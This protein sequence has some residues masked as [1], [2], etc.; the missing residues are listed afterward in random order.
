LTGYFHLK[1]QVVYFLYVESPD[2]NINYHHLHS[3]ADY[4][5][6]T[7]AKS[8]FHG[9]DVVSDIVASKVPYDGSEM[10]EFVIETQINTLYGIEAT[11]FTSVQ[12]NDKIYFVLNREYG[13]YSFNFHPQLFAIDTLGQ[14]IFSR[15]FV[16]VEA[17]FEV[18][19][20]IN[21]TNDNG[22]VMVG[23]RDY[24][25]NNR[26]L[27]M[28]RLDSL[29]H[30]L[31]EKEIYYQAQY[32]AEGFCVAQMPDGDFIISGSTYIGTSPYG[33]FQIYYARTDSMGNVIWEHD[34]GADNVLDAPAKVYLENDT[35][36]IIFGGYNQEPFIGRVTGDGELYDETYLDVGPQSNSRLFL[37]LDSTYII[38][39]YT[40][41][42][43]A[44]NYLQ[45][46]DQEFN[47]LETRTLYL[48]SLNTVQ[49]QDMKL[50]KDCSLVMCGYKFSSPLQGYLLKT[51][52]TGETCPEPN[53]YD[54]YENEY[55]DCM[56]TGID[57]GIPPPSSEFM[58]YPNPV[59]DKFTIT[60]KDQF[61]RPQGIRLYTSDG[62]QVME[63]NYRD[64]VDLS[65]YSS[66]LYLLELVGEGISYYGKIVKTQ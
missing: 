24:D 11:G 23:T 32:R 2:T 15:E 33:E 37:R 19:Y 3:F 47:L 61:I 21:K 13:L 17:V 18:I 29:G 60:L 20:A 62:R 34:F 63:M 65:D 39:Y 16:L 9:N 5:I 10:E 56:D 66:G 6:V 53:C 43:L 50:G 30:L 59:I 35:S 40:Y 58:N 42:G 52:L 64:E 45:Y 44:H 54:E 57:T 8:Y 22:I 48:D 7:G 27:L 26:P 1:A 31:W 25:L 55:A 12:I 51:D 41:Y 38:H 36:I 46:F 28:L 4:S 14:L 49:I